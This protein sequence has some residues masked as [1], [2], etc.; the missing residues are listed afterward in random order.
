VD[1]WSSDETDNRIVCEVQVRADVQWLLCVLRLPTR[2]M[3]VRLRAFH[4]LLS[5][6]QDMHGNYV[7]MRNLMSS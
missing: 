4:K 1:K 2:T 6:Q 5:E 7:L 3:Q